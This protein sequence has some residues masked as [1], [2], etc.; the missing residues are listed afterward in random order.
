MYI[1]YPIVLVL[2]EMLSP[3]SWEAG[4]GVPHLGQVPNESFKTEV[5]QGEGE[6]GR[7]GFYCSQLTGVH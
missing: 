2:I 4:G 5:V 7:K 3:S 6:V 1:C